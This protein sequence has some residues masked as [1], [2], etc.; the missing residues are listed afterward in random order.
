MFALSMWNS[1]V[2][3]Y[4]LLGVTLVVLTGALIVAVSRV[5]S[6]RTVDCP[7]SGRAAHIL[8]ESE[9]RMPWSSTRRTAVAHCSL[10]PGGVTCAQGCLHCPGKDHG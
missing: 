1:V 7:A 8:V 3:I 6:A 2:P 4:S 10:L 9:K 5:L